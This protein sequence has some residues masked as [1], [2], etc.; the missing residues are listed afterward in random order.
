M[1][2]ESESSK[3]NKSSINLRRLWHLLLMVIILLLLF[4]VAVILHNEINNE[5][6]LVGFFKELNE[7]EK[8]LSRLDSTNLDYIKGQESLIK[9]LNTNNKEDI[10]DYFN[11][12]QQVKNMTDTVHYN[13]S[14]YE[15]K[16]TGK[17]VQV[18]DFELS[19]KL[20]HL[21][22]SLSQNSMM[23]VDQ[24]KD[25]RPR[26]ESLEFDDLAVKISIETETKVDSVE[27]KGLFGRLGD[28]LGGKV[29]VQKEENNTLMI[30]EYGGERTEGSLDE[31]M[32]N[33][34]KM[35]SE[36]YEKELQKLNQHFSQLIQKN[37]NLLVNAISIQNLSS[38]VFA[39]YKEALIE[40]KEVLSEKYNTQ[41]TNNRTIRLYTLL[42]LAS[43]LIFLAFAVIYLTKTTYDIEKKLVVAKENL[44]D[45]LKL[46]NKMV[47]MISH[48]IRSPL[49]IILLYIKQILKLEKDPKKTAVLNSIGDTTNSAFLLANRI[50]DYSK[51]EKRQMTIYRDEFNLH[52][53]ID[54]VFTGFNTLAKSKS[55]SLINTNNINPDTEVIFDRSKLHSL[56]FNLLDNAIKYADDGDIEVKSE[57]TETKDGKFK[58]S[59]SVKDSGKGIPEESLKK[60]FESFQDVSTTMQENQNLDVGFGLYFCKEITELFDGNL[61][62]Q[63]KPNEGTTVT[64]TVYMD[65]N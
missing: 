19:D 25:V 12:L 44:T 46:K 45:N 64:A 28:A 13:M 15:I 37:K 58:F 56:Y 39:Q 52:E 30:L 59:L 38:E 6:K 36:Y 18:K 16:N 32:S 33:V 57:A 42:G 4:C 62:I 9:Y 20:N 29:D 14:E 21:I 23:Y 5:K 27:K 40:Q 34:L 48:D 53:E 22:D 1:V 49:N 2:T 50:L 43:L 10:Q 35:G 26:Y 61:E 8:L 41:Y 55:K 3:I 7:T 47:S 11:S 63:S 60:I 54:N 31:Q 17:G 51:K 65:N 24:K